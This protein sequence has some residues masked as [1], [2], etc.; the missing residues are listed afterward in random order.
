M[1]DLHTT[2]VLGGTFDPIHIGHLTL[3]RS[4]LSFLPLDHLLILPT[5]MPWQKQR[6]V[7]PANHRLA[8]LNIAFNDWA[9]V[10]IDPLETELATPSYS[11]ESLKTLRQRLGPDERIVMILGSDQFQN[12]QSWHRWQELLNLAH[13]AVTQRERV[14]LSNLP[15]AIDEFLSRYGVQ[16]LPQTPNGSIVLFSMPP[17]AVSSTVLRKQLSSIDLDQS[18]GNASNPLRDA[19]SFL[20]PP[21]VLHYINQ[22]RLY[23]PNT[24]KKVL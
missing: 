21:G 22:H 4:A 16:Q 2:G 6:L 24:E 9:K 12:L 13:I 8:M 5:G 3:A 20:L 1:T 10:S 23:L 17:V 18:Q 19:A 11:Y 15:P 7:T 14:S